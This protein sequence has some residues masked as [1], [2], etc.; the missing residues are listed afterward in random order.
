MPRYYFKLIGAFT[1]EPE[2]D[3][4]VETGTTVGEVKA[5]LK[6]RYHLA[7]FLEVK[8]IHEGRTLTEDDKVWER[9]VGAPKKKPITFLAVRS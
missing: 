2:R 4:L 6:K 9:V 3:L 8:V 1:G 5:A 7:P